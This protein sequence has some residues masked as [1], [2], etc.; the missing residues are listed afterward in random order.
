MPKFVLHSN[1]VC[2]VVGNDNT[3]P[4]ICSNFVFWKA[5]SSPF[6]ERLKLSESGQTSFIPR[7][8]T[9]LVRMFWMSGLAVVLFL[10][11]PSDDSIV[12]LS[13]LRRDIKQRRGRTNTCKRILAVAT[14]PLALLVENLQWKVEHCFQIEFMSSSTSLVLSPQPWR[15]TVFLQ[16]FTALDRLVPSGVF[17]F[18]I[19]SWSNSRKIFPPCSLN[20]S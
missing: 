6:V 1:H 10:S 17:L 4:L 14:V 12:T 20:L 15:Q 18:Q 16:H 11:R 9:K 19:M 8:I 3:T 2:V 13:V 7:L 5:R